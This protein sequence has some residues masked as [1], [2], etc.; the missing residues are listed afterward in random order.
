MF[1]T[2]IKTQAS[3]EQ[4]NVWLDKVWQYHSH[5]ALSLCSGADGLLRLKRQSSLVLMLKLSSGMDQT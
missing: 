5:Q 3:K 4:Q 2:F 1:L